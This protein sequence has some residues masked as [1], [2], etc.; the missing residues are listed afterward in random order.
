MGRAE[1]GRLEGS[2]GGNFARSGAIGYAWLRWTAARPA[3][4]SPLGNFAA[5]SKRHVASFS[6]CT[7]QADDTDEGLVGSVVGTE[8]YA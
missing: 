3:V 5:I 8:D 1:R 4:R 6:L 2:Q 7:G